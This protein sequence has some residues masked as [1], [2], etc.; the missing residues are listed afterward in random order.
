MTITSNTLTLINY[1]WETEKHHYE[2]LYLDSEYKEGDAL[3]PD[4][5]ADAHIFVTLVNLKKE[6]GA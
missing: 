4:A 3:H 6:L 1:L 2:E 5:I